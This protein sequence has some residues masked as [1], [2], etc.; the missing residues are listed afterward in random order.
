MTLFPERSAMH[1]RRRLR[2]GIP[3]LLAMGL[4]A[5]ISLSASA[6]PLAQVTKSA[7]PTPLTAEDVGAWL[8]GFLPY[9]LYTGDIAGAVVVVVKD[10]KV[11]C[12]KGYGYADVATRR[13]VT[14]DTTLFRLASISK[15]FTWTAVMQLVQAGALDLDADINR[16]LDFEIPPADG[17]PI[18]LRELMTHTAGFE[19][20]N[21]NLL[22][23]S[24]ASLLPLGRYEREATPA[25]IFPPGKVAAYSNYGA[26]LAG[27]IVQRVSG[28]PFEEYVERH[29]FAPLGMAHATFRQPLPTT[30]SAD[31][32]RSYEL[33]SGPARYLEFSNPP[34]AGALSASGS[35]IARFMI[36]HLNDGRF[37][38]AQILQPATT[39]LMQARA[40][41]TSPEINGM[42][43]GFFETD[44]N[45]HRAIGHGGDL[46]YF[47]SDLNLLP[48][49]HVGLFVALNSAGTGT[50]NIAI[51]L[52]LYRG[53]VD[54]YFPASAPDLTRWRNAEPDGRLVT[55]SYESSR[56]GQTTVL[57]ALRLAEQI[58]VRMLANGDLTLPLLD[59]LTGS[60]HRTWQEIAPFLW[61]E[62]GGKSRIAAI[63]RDGRV[64]AL[65]TDAVPAF[66]ILQPVP[67][68]LRQGWLAPALAGAVAVLALAAILW[69]VGALVRW[70]NGGL[71]LRGSV[72]RLDRVICATALVNLA[73]LTGWA[74]T[75]IFVF[76]HLTH[77][78]TRLDPWLRALQ[79]VGVLGLLGGGVALWNLLFV[80]QDNQRGWLAKLSNLLI[81]VAI[82]IVAWVEF[83]SHVFSPSLNY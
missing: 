9:A 2:W 12:E 44:R 27:Y 80:L 15:L 36:A 35:D 46:T 1:L 32:S 68:G 64:E 51:R 58:R 83:V 11:L 34:P 59:A 63:V 29:I 5:G 61:Q 4:M 7:V 14:P 40:Y 23:R 38:T 31:M 67:W 62:V 26:G 75:L 56:R 25:R 53:F 16:Y 30:L 28:E 69:P 60:P 52:Q 57:S 17:K 3:T 79:A 81:V 78:N 70:W 8:D 71:P 47:H 72:A 18:T 45:G 43:L 66:A 20:H 21:K 48:D 13:L 74:A 6:Q 37:G 41:R 22:V 49:D 10:D 76:L 42:T 73:F 19:E 50:A 82:G 24:E 39:R 65:T 55:G 77:A 54:R 33:G